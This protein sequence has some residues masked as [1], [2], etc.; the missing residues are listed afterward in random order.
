MHKIRDQGAPSVERLVQLIDARL[1]TWDGARAFLEVVRCGSFRAAAQ[2]LTI[3]ANTLRRLVDGFERE[4]AITLLTRHVDGV[5]LTAEGELLI[6]A[7]KRMDAA[8]FDIARVRNFGVSMRGEVRLSVTEGVGT[9]WVAPRLVDFQ[10][11]YPGLLIDVRCAMHPADVLRLET[12]IGIQIVRPNAKDLR[13]VKLG[14]MHA[15]PFA[16]Q[17]YLDTYG[18]PTTIAS[19]E[20]AARRKMEQLADRAS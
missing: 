10:R 2:T 15:M 12:D 14:R 7:V 5:R 6:G 13:I 9:F 8:S 20:L 3:S 16:S 18:H 11:A 4:I 19:P 1:R 17:S